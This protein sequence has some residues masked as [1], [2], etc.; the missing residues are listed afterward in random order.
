MPRTA[1]LAG[2]LLGRGKAAVFLGAV[3]ALASAGTASAATVTPAAQP[4]AISRAAASVSHARLARAAGPLGPV[5]LTAAAGGAGSFGN[6][7]LGTGSGHPANPLFDPAAAAGQSPLAAPLP[8]PHPAAAHRAGPARLAAAHPAAPAQSVTPAPPA[9]A[10]APA[11]PAQPYLIYDSVTPSAIPPGHEIA[12]YAT[13]GYAVP[14]SAVAGRP[15]LWIDTNGSDPGAGALDV[16]PGDATPQLA[17]SW[18]QQK[19]TADPGALARIY[20][21]RSEW[22]AVQA[23]IAALPARMQAQVRWWIADPTGVPH[24]VPGSQATQWYWG[25]SYDISTAAPNF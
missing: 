25:P 22:P 15:V 19:L 12:T 6:P 7:L 20:T 9:A 10:P 3:A 18:V 21:M 1:R 2:A 24:L 14:A 13:G 23:A 5:S 4:A 8:G 16:E 11:P 17:A